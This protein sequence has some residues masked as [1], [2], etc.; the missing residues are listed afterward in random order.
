MHDMH[1]HSEFSIDSHEPMGAYLPIAR[2]FGVESICFTEHVDYNPNDFGKDFFEVSRYF[3]A[4][5]DVRKEAE[6]IRI[7]SG[8]EFDCPHQY[9]QMF[10]KEC[11]LPYDCIIG[12][13]H[14]CNLMPD[15][16]LSDLV[17]SGV[18]AKDCFTAYWRE[19]KK[20]VRLGGFEVLGHMDIP[21]RYYHELYYDEGVLREIFRMMLD[22]NIV[23][24]INTS[25]LRKG[26]QDTLPGR[27]LLQIYR[28]EGGLYVTVG[29]DAH[30]AGELSADNDIA[31]TLVRE[32]SL[33]E[34]IFIGRK[35]VQPYVS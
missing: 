27:E 24:E 30:V 23:P 16:F 2:R 18:S 31:Q 15:I 13:V 29:S 22:K 1:V 8:I 5:Q 34:V 7:L 21:K 28:Q 9:P 33:N 4:I 35:M 25:S 12:S 10:E 11:L 6:G 19:V 32:L 17:A 26:C 14:Y 3:D 20:T